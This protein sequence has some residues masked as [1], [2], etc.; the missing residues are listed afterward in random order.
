[1][2]QVARKYGKTEER[3]GPALAEMLVIPRDGPSI[4]PGRASFGRR[5]G[6]FTSAHAA[7]T[8]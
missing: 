7:R 1:L 2:E 8:G 5:G 4:R 3:F 6:R